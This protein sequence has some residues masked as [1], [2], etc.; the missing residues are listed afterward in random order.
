MGVADAA[1]QVV[2]GGAADAERSA[3]VGVDVAAVAAGVLCT[4]AADEL[5]DDAGA[6]AVVVA[7]VL[8]EPFELAAFALSSCRCC[9]PVAGDVASMW[10]H[11]CTPRTTWPI[12]IDSLLISSPS[13]AVSSANPEEHSAF[14]V[15]TSGH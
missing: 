2:A 11:R 13:E 15:S 4:G 5:E 7:A 6:A 12:G 8:V 9:G 14:V 3:A 1:E 10:W